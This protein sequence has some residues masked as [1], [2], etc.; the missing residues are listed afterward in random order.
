MELKF[1]N[2]LNKSNEIG[3]SN[4]I[5]EHFHCIFISR[6]DELTSRLILSIN[7]L[8][9]LL[10]FV[11]KDLRAIVLKYTLQLGLK[12]LCDLISF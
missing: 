3:C 1:D 8:F 4:I 6:Q 12:H 7:E 10:C 2:S 9:D 5:F 11:L